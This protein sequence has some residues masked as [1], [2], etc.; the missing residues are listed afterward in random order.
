MQIEAG[1]E[2]L[3][4]IYKQTEAKL[5]LL[6]LEGS[7]GDV[8]AVTESIGLRVHASFAARMSALYR[9][10]HKGAGKVLYVE[11]YSYFDRIELRLRYG[12]SRGPRKDAQRI[13][14]NARVASMHRLQDRK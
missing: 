10:T 14:H 7:V 1:S 12:T 3:K 6:G 5:L 2:V 11:D 13:A 8:V 9:H 4:E